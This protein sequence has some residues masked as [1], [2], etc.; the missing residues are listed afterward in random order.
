MPGLSGGPGHMGETGLPPVLVGH[1]I[2]GG[3]PL[4]R[5][6]GILVRHLIALDGVMAQRAMASLSLASILM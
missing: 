1:V 2:V 6:P 3:E 4:G 5:C